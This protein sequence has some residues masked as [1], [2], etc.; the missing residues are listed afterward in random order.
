M[1]PSTL[2]N[3]IYGNYFAKDISYKLLF[4]THADGSIATSKDKVITLDSLFESIPQLQIREF[5]PDTRLDQC[6]NLFAELIDEIMDSG[7]QVLGGALDVLK[8]LFSDSMS[9][10]A[11]LEAL[12][13]VLKSSF[14]FIV[15]NVGDGEAWFLKNKQG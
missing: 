11:R 10:T 5:L 8:S 6:I 14:D 13:H 15:G 4:E 12:G 2:T 9:A 3:P 1:C 7:K